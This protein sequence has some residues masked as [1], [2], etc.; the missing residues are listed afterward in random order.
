MASIIYVEEEKDEIILLNNIP[1]QE[2]LLG[3]AGRLSLR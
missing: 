3:G 2:T 1:K